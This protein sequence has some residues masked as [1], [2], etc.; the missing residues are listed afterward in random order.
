M[1]RAGDDDDEGGNL[2]GIDE[3]EADFDFG[4]EV[5]RTAAAEDGADVDAE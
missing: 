1:S 2:A 3:A 5:E 4:G